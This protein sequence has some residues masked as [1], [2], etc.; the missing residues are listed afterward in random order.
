MK[1]RQIFKNLI[2]YLK[3]ETIQGP[4]LVH[5]LISSKLWLGRY[6]RISRFIHVVYL[7]ILRVGQKTNG[8]IPNKLIQW[9]VIV[10]W[11]E[12]FCAKTLGVLMYLGVKN[13]YVNC[14]LSRDLMCPPGC[15]HACCAITY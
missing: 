15:D 5:S 3:W 12:R 14:M 6:L 11:S 13:R 7:Q 8:R 4:A 9:S 1:N 10:I 2:K